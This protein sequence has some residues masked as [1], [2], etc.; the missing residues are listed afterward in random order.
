MFMKTILFTIPFC[1]LLSAGHGQFYNDGDIYNDGELMNAKVWLFDVSG[2]N[3]PVNITRSSLK[4][5]IPMSS[6]PAGKYKLQ[7]IK[8]REIKTFKIVKL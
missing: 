8:D 7:V 4:Y 5:E 3:L 1:L 6:V 2:R